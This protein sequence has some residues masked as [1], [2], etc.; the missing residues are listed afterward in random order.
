MELSDLSTHFGDLL[1]HFVVREHRSA[2]QLADI[3]GVP[4]KTIQSWLEGRVARPRDWRGI[5][6]VAAALNLTR[7][8]VN[9][10]LNAANHRSIEELSSFVR[11]A[12]EQQMLDLLVRWETGEPSVA[13]TAPPVNPDAVFQ[14]VPAPARMVGRD[15]ELAQLKQFMRAGRQ[16][17]MLLGM[18]GVGKTAL[19][20]QAAYE[21]R[22]E[23]PDGVLW[24]QVDKSDTMSIL[25]SFAYAF[26][27]EVSELQDV[28]T[29]SAVVRDVLAKKKCLIVLD[30]T[31]QTEEIHLL[32]PPSTSPSVVL[33]TTTN[34][35]ILDTEAAVIELQ[36]FD[37]QQRSAGLAF[38]ADLPI[39]PADGEEVKAL[40][41]MIDL[42]GGLPLALRIIASD[43]N[44]SSYL[45]AAEYYDY[46]Y[47]ERT[48]LENL[49]D[50]QET[51]KDVRASFEMSYNRLPTTL[52][53]LFCSLA[54][55]KKAEFSVEAAAAV[56]Q[57]PLPKMKKALSQLEALSLIEPYAVRD[58]SWLAVEPAGASVH[59]ERYRLHTLLFIFVTEKLA[60]LQTDYH[61]R[62][63]GYYSQYVQRHQQQN[64][65]IALEWENIAALV[66]WGAAVPI[67]EHFLSL[68]EALT[69]PQ[70][71]VVGFL[72]ARGYW[73]QAHQWVI[74]ALQLDQPDQFLQARLHFRCGFFALRLALA[75][76]A[77]AQL[78]QAAHLLSGLADTEAHALYR[79]YVYE[80]LAQRWMSRDRQ[81]ALAW[82]E[83][84]ISALAHVQSAI[85]QQQRG[86]LLIRHGTI[87][88]QRGDLVAGQELIE[89]AFTLLPE[90]PTAARISGL[91]SL[92]NIFDIQGDTDRARHCWLEG[93]Q[94]A[95]ALADYRRLAGLWLN[96]AIQ[97]EE[98]G[99]FAACEEFN[100]RALQ[101][102]RQIGDL[103]GEGRVLSN[104]AFNYLRQEKFAQAWPY[105]EEAARLTATHALPDLE[106]HVKTNYARYYFLQGHLAQAEAFLAEAQ[107]LSA[108]IEESETLSEITRLQAQVALQQGDYTTALTLIETSLA[109]A[110]D[111]GSEAGL[112]WGVK[113]E[114]LMHQG[115]AAESRTAFQQSI[116]LLARY[117]FDQAKV[118]AVWADC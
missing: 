45:S 77:E 34:R 24:A 54:V 7:L 81:Q 62:A 61:A 70:I 51:S 90:E 58:R 99:Q 57:M 95:E 12:Q 64:G 63:L 53:S 25:Y 52:K 17:C 76:A 35:R 4:L 55:F 49:S 44:Q 38:F 69:L 32:R 28:E 13:P 36:P 106:V 112:G 60:T 108:Q 2:G 118:K 30:S 86:Y 59:L 87:L 80:T 104:L 3:T 23:F 18:P 79:S 26:G 78:Q 67:A 94:A 82:S 72:D 98:Q 68:L 9:R 88:A 43:L 37:G 85:G 21:L 8:E 65:L 111:Q 89:E 48:R 113:G 109:A 50:W 66:D 29:R 19:A 110:D 100:E 96:L 71:G 27:R 5:L 105:L 14:A 91:L 93:V 47:D 75:T 84:G 103:D 73:R 56:V 39:D 117:P 102:Y 114:I 83:Q 92:G 101:L 116:E 46:L 42:V 97:A 16:I 20:A 6:T 115:K 31:Y 1:Q 15:R 40:E 22:T 33:I 107:A 10:L 74:C 41:K 11:A